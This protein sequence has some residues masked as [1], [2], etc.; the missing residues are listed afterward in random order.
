MKFSSEERA[1]LDAAAE[2]I[3]VCHVYRGLA[4]D[5]AEHERDLT[6]QRLAAQGLLSCVEPVGYRKTACGGSAS[7]Y[8]LT[9]A[10]RDAL[11][12]DAGR[13]AALAA[14]FGR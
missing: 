4:V 10:G 13:R 11:A 1:V 12:A 5:G 2:G 14:L 3:L 9:R 6:A 7:R 8:T